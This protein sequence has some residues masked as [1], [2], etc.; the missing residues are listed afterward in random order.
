LITILQV[1]HHGSLC[2][3]CLH[4]LLCHQ[5]GSLFGLGQTIQGP[6]VILQLCYLP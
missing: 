2:L 1:I 4:C 3:S 6:I 5:K